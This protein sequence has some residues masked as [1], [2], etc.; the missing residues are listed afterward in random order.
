MLK[1]RWRFFLILIGLLGICGG[2]LW[3]KTQWQDSQSTAPSGQSANQP[4]TTSAKNVHLILGN[5]SNAGTAANNYLLLRAQYALSYNNTKHIP[6]WVS[7]QLNRSW[8]GNIPRSE[9]FRPDESLPS[10]WYQVKSSDYNDSGFDRGHMTPA[11]DRSDTGKNNSATFLMTNILPQA[12]DNNQGPWEKLERYCRELVAPGKELYIIAGGYGDRG[13]VGRG[14][15][16]ITIPERV[17][18]VVVVLDKPGQGVAGVTTKTRVIAVDMPNIQGIEAMS[19]RTYRVTARLL[20]KKTG[21]NFLSN[22][23]QS[24]QDVIETRIDR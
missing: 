8:L 24:I 23:P 9:D 7:W 1:S 15:A 5:P 18:K 10:G 20:E 14:N 17:W 13:G 3:L 21:Y 22:V 6:N 11:A 16:R 19:W 4:L 12:P 2:A